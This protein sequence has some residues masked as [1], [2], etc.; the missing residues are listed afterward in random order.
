[1][2]LSMMPTAKKKL[3]GMGLF[4]RGPADSNVNG[5]G[6]SPRAAVVGLPATPAP[7]RADTGHTQLPQL[8][9]PPEIVS[10]RQDQNHVG[11]SPRSI[12]VPKAGRYA[13]LS[14]QPVVAM[15]LPPQQN[16]HFHPMQRTRTSASDHARDPPRGQNAWEDSTVGSMFGDHES[17]AASD[18]HRGHQGN[19]GRQH[20]DAAYHRPQ[21]QSHATRGNQNQQAQHDEN[22]PFVFGEN[23]VLK[24]ITAS[25]G[26]HMS[27]AAAALNTTIS[28]NLLSEQA[29]TVDDIYQDDRNVY[30][31]TPPKTNPLRRTKLPRRDAQEL[32]RNSFSDRGG[33]GY[34]SDAQSLGMSP[35]RNSEAGEQIEKVRLEERVR[36]DRERERSR[37]IERELELERQRERELQHKR[38]TVFENL[39]PVDTDE[40]NFN[41]TRAAVVV[42]SSDISAEDVQEALQRTP[43]ANR[44]VKPPPITIQP[45]NLFKP[46]GILVRTSSRRQIQQPSA[47]ESLTR[48]R[49]HSVDYD[50][51]ELNK[52]SFSDLRSQAFD[53][54]PQAAAAMVVQQRQVTSG[55]VEGPIEERLAH[56]KTQG[57]MDQHEFFTRISA[58]EWDESGDWFL[59][60]FTSVVTKLKNARRAKRKLVEKF[61]D[62]IAQREEAVRIKVEGIGR[63]LEDLKEEGQTMMKGKE[64]ELEF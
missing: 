55:P 26:P 41:D 52:M 12:P 60:Q 36:R 50:D 32:K 63:T 13:N 49:R 14:N 35:E 22:L 24:V 62:E 58:D 29:V 17:R 23:G 3:G 48:K 56:Y 31:S 1:M 45:T 20:S 9:P 5:P 43:R 57:S 18:R 28:N 64:T 21:N 4:L 59:E 46:E 54:D 2:R 39:T 38:S 30:E 16:Q 40:P 25:S 33:G 42:P 37:E 8:Q 6:G 47:K 10:S 53:Y 27:G 34:A 44:Q 19:H 61:E 7:V 11:G 15:S 51:S